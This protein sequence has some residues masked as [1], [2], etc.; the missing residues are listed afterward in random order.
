MSEIK[1][2]VQKYYGE[3]L[4]S[5]ADLKTSA[6]CTPEAMPGWVKEIL[7][8]IH[9]E[10][11][12]K[13]YGCGLVVP[14]ALTGARVLDLGCGAGRD[15]FILSKIVGDAGEVVG[16]D[17]THEQIES[18]RRHQE[19]HRE[20]FGH[21]RLNTQ[22]IQGDIQELL[23]LGLR[24]GSFDV[25]VSNCVINL[26]EDK[27]KVL[28]EVFDLLKEGGELYFSDVYASRRISQ[29]L[30]R[31]PVARGE[32]LSGALYWNDFHQMAKRAGFR[33]PRI[34]DSRP[35]SIADTDLAEKLTGIEFFSVTYRLF[36]LPRLEAACEDYGQAVIYQ[37]SI[38]DAPK[39]YLLDAHHYFEKGKTVS[40][41]GNTWM[42]L[43]DT[44]LRDHFNFIGNFETHFGI[45]P[46]C[47]TDIPYQ[48]SGG[49][50][51]AAGGA[52]C[53]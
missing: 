46:G 6:C 33:D 7:K 16:V 29:E 23:A 10:P 1:A 36:K 27:Q 42:M 17:F 22:F 14:H 18:A 45:F 8:L 32:C 31:D 34:V 12:A 44:R 35:L 39:G 25:V 51:G 24:P 49:V 30:Q 48:R 38:A 28:N 52:C 50:S 26:V 37:G 3:T 11:M 41:C 5:S 4:R 20:K 13:Y 53:P 40:V 21:R 43:Q 15:V 19:W 2:A 47:G 9:D